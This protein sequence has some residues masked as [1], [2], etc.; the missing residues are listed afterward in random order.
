MNVLLDQERKKY[1]MELW[2]KKD[3]ETEDKV[4]KFPY[5]RWYVMRMITLEVGQE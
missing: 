2:S 5:A 1:P 3:V 4:T